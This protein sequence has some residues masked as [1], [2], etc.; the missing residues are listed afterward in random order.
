M[1]GFDG[2]MF[3]PKLFLRHIGLHLQTVT[4]FF[5]G[6]IYIVLSTCYGCASEDDRTVRFPG[7]WVICVRDKGVG[8]LQAETLLCVLVL[9]FTVNP[10][11]VSLVA[12]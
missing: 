11:F 4:F 1:C 12:L 10:A 5:K 9:T 8:N 7:Q 6:V 2:Q 3:L